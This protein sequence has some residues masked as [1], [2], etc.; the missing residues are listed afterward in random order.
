[1]RSNLFRPLAGFCGLAVVVLVSI[2]A[3]AVTALIGI[4]ARLAFLWLANI[5]LR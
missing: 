5:I 4:V 1:M 3:V 2:G